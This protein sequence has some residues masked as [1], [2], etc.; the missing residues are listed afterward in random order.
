[1]NLHALSHAVRTGLIVYLGGRLFMT[2][3]RHARAAWRLIQLDIR[4][5]QPIEVHGEEDAL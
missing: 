4:A 3:G 5:A 1:V 2:D